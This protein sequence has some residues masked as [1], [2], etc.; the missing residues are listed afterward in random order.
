MSGIVLDQ[1]SINWIQD[2]TRNYNRDHLLRNTPRVPDMGISNG[3]CMD[4]KY[5][6]TRS[7]LT[8]EQ[9][10]FDQEMFAGFKGFVEESDA[11]K[12]MTSL[13]VGIDNY[14]ALAQT[15]NSP[16]LPDKSISTDV[17]HSVTAL[18]ARDRHRNARFIE[19]MAMPMTD[20]ERRDR[21]AALFGYAHLG[22]T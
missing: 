14:V 8:P 1:E 15:M 9:S 22:G 18:Q 5:S 13:Q 21:I 10:H 17:M 6:A 19:L 11:E 2:A 12:A 4:Y 16:L 7:D 20:A 3:A